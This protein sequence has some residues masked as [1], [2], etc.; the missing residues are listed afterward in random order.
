MSPSTHWA[1]YMA[2]DS[3]TTILL[4]STQPIKRC[5]VYKG[6]KY[7]YDDRCPGRIIIKPVKRKK[8]KAEIRRIRS[9]VSKRLWQRADYRQAV[10]SGVRNSWRDP[11]VRRKR[12]EGIKKKGSAAA[13]KRWQDP[14]YRQTMSQVQILKW[15][16]ASPECK[17]RMNN[18]P[19]PL[20]VL[21]SEVELDLQV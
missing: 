5:S 10:S 12:V 17:A 19:R 11:E 6:F 15:H 9:S 21:L 4:M 2:R 14:K 8:S 3:V 1:N 16:R 18:L 20:G 13:L 7:I